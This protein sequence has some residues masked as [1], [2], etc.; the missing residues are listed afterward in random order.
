M[1]YYAVIG[2]LLQHRVVGWL[3]SAVVH[4]AALG[5]LWSIG[6]SEDEPPQPSE[7][8]ALRLVGE[9]ISVAP[10][11]AAPSASWLEELEA[12]RQ[13]AAQP[14]DESR[15]DVLIHPREA[16]I[17]QRV[18]RQANA[19][20]AGEVVPLPEG[21]PSPATHALVALP[22]SVRDETPWA[23]APRPIAAPRAEPP[24][25]QLPSA[26][27]P[28]QE[29]GVQGHDELD[30][31]R[32]VF[33]PLPVYPTAAQ[34]AGLS[35]TVVLHIDVGAEGNV[36]AVRLAASSGHAVLDAAALQAA[37]RWR[38]RPAQRD[39][40]PVAMTVRYEIEFRP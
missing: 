26:A 5:V 22:R 13:H 16:R 25:A 37:R 27:A 9:M 11:R 29:V 35:G 3:S 19:A 18:F 6:L 39:G 30:V 10:M 8:R 23:D 20:T 24:V 2:W 17:D 33:N 40:R 4:G 38:F 1:R 28:P 31:P 7:V 15:A 21:V 32:A 12:L 36:S 14:A 34:R